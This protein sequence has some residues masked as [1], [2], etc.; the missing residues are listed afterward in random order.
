MDG[1]AL[2]GPVIRDLR[3]RIQAG[4]LARGSGCEQRED[5]CSDYLRQIGTQITLTRPLKVIV[6]CGNGIAGEPAPFLLRALGCEVVELHCRVDGRFP[7][8]H[9]DPS[10]PENL[11]ELCAKVPALGADLGL[12]FDGDADRLGVVS[13]AGEIIW[14]AS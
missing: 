7:H 9:P 11:A 3:R 14:P 1:M 6:D 10:Q 2:H 4:E 13:D 12:A 8:H 5:L